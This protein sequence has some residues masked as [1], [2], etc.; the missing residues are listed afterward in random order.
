[1][2]FALGL[3]SGLLYRSQQHIEAERKFHA[4]DLTVQGYLHF[5]DAVIG[6]DEALD[7]TRRAIALSD[8]DL[9]GPADDAWRLMN[10]PQEYETG[11]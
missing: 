3:L 6:C 2:F 9:P 4:C 1:V 11:E 10:M 7:A 8:C 5:N